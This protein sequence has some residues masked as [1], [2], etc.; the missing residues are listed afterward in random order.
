MKIKQSILKCF[1]L[2]ITPLIMA[3]ASL[4]AQQVLKPQ[5]AF[6]VEAFVQNDVIQVNHRI[7]DGYYLYKN[8]ISY[9]SIQD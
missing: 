9:R 2:V 6:P 3:S 5:E 8:K 7:E 1:S 4:F